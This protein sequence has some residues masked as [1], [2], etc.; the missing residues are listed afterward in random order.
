VTVTL[1]A[2]ITL[3]GAQAVKHFDVTV[4]SLAPPTPIAA[5]D[6]EDDLDAS[7]G[8]FGPGVAVGSRPDLPGGSVAFDTGGGHLRRGVREKC[9][10][11]C[12]GLM[13]GLMVRT[14]PRPYGQAPGRGTKH[15]ASVLWG[16][17]GRRIHR[18]H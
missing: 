14:M 2:T 9:A 1:T 3:E 10:E 18:H 16:R 11:P 4:R 15:R 8:V 6:F 17:E 12:P 5:Y 7:A 13:A